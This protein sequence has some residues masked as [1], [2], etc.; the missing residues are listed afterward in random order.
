MSAQ[1]ET[2]GHNETNL[3]DETHIAYFVVPVIAVFTKY[4]QFKDNIAIR[5]KRRRDAN[6][7]INAPAEMERVFREEYLGKL[8]GTPHFVRLEG[9]V[10]NHG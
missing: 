7:E 9:G 1:T 3:Y 2:V 10:L 4:D 8:G 5:L 6:S